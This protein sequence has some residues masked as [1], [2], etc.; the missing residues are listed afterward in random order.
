MLNTI[1]PAINTVA[2]ADGMTI[3][4]PNKIHNARTISKIPQTMMSVA[5]GR[6]A[7]IK[8]GKYP[9]HE[10]GLRKPAIPAYVSGKAIPIFS[11]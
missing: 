5:P 11:K 6:I 9:I 8:R 4:V 10:D 2:I 3:F 1:T 7:C